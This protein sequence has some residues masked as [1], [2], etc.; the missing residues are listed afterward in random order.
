MAAGSN[1]GNF[2]Q[3]RKFNRT[4][5]LTALVVIIAFLFHLDVLLFS[6]SEDEIVSQFHRTKAIY[7]QG[8][9]NGALVR[10]QR[11]IGII[12]EKGI[13]RK[14]ILGKC[15]LLLGAIFEKK[16]EPDRA[17]EHYRKA[18]ETY[19]IT[20]V[21][22]VD[23]EALPL[24]RK[25]VEGEGQLSQPD[26]STKGTI[27]KAGS[28]KKKKKKFP[29]LLVA[30]GVVVVTII[31][32]LLL[33]KKKKYTLTVNKGTGVDGSPD[34]GVHTYSKGEQVSYNYTAQPGYGNLTVLLDN[35]PI[36]SSGTI[37]MDGNHTLTVTTDSLGFIT[38]TEE[39]EVPEKGTATFNVRLSVRPPNDIHVR[40]SNAGGDADIE[41]KDGNVFTFTTDN[42]ESPRTVTLFAAEDNDAENDEATIRIE[43]LGGEVPNKEITARE[44]ESNQLLFE[45]DRETVQVAEKGYGTFKL[46]LTSAPAGTVV[47]RVTWTSGDT[48]ISITEPAEFSFTP[49][50]Y[51]IYQ[52]VILEAKAD[53]D[54]ER[55]EALFTI[56]ADT[57]RP[58]DKVIKAVEIDSDQNHIITNLAEDTIIVDEKGSAAVQVKLSHQP[59]GTVTVNITRDSG[60]SDIT[61][62]APGT[63]EFNTS[64]WNEFK[65]FSLSAADDDDGKNGEATI[66]IGAVGYQSKYITAI[67]ADI[68]RYIFEVD[69]NP[70][71]VEEGSSTTFQVKLGAKPDSEVRV[72]IEK[73]GGDEDISIQAPS[74]RLTFTPETWDIF[75]SVTLNAARDEDEQDGEANLSISAQ[76]FLTSHVIARESDTYK[77]EPPRISFTTLNDGDTVYDDVTID[78]SPEDDIGITKVEFYV[79]GTLLGEDTQAY[80]R[81]EWSTKDAEIKAHELKVIA[82]DS[83]L[84][85]AE[86][87]IMVNVGDSL[88]S[89]T[90]ISLSPDTSPASG[91]VTVNIEASDYRGV[92]KIEFYVD[93]VLVPDATWTGSP[94][95]EV[96]HN[97][98]L[99]TT[100]YTNGTSTFKAI[101]TD[102]GDQVSTAYE[103]SV[104][105]QN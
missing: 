27:E 59:S 50:N 104:T 73:A 55:G 32:I 3:T 71:I 30:G 74:N 6:Q 9:H 11:L 78:A 49:L 40:V 52:T 10:L 19:G 95:S 47:A 88:P 86:A 18:R 34:S 23:L 13:D 17:E 31:A 35:N 98:Q 8:Q 87:T 56:S 42:W 68:D 65:S 80:Y 38:S 99:D 48:D 20:L 79:D 91:I 39:V 72:D 25:T 54:T 85:T 60:D 103:I 14:D 105:I 44:V 43:A 37:N 33:K 7:I 16:A 58:P 89:I 57:E 28:K 53:G 81:M 1:V 90:D 76:G 15:H 29:W 102:S 45:T 5:K 100:A 51:N 75:Q 61:V 63:I 4:S 94:S 97:F 82:Y 24:Y 84:Q 36:E 26:Q 22:G 64:D 96:S 67:E 2:R 93:D 12:E 46:R 66:R 21:D 70:V 101:A 69:K 77:G 62:D 41:V 92:Q 83:I